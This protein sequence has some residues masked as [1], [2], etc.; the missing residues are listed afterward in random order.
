MLQASGSPAGDHS[1]G[2]GAAV[3]V[4]EHLHARLVAAYHHHTAAQ[5]FVYASHRVKAVGSRLG[6]ED[7]SGVDER[8]ACTV[9][10]RR[11]QGEGSGGEGRARL[12]ALRKHFLPVLEAQHYLTPHFLH[13]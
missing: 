6:A 13:H 8:R 11:A 5:R 3:E 9:E 4:S 7:W 1:K 2:L 10:V 12:P